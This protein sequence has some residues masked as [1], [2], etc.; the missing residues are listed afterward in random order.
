MK[1][2]VPHLS[3]DGWITNKKIKCNKI[4]EY[5]IT[6]EYSQSVTFNG[7]ISSLKYLLAE[8]NDID[9]FKGNLINTLT[10][11]YKRYFDIVDVIVEV[12]LDESVATYNINI[13]IIIND[14]GEE[15]VFSKVLYTVDGNIVNMDDLLTN[16]Y[17]E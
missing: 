10:T 16:L 5:F 12:S 4:F 6:S 1:N 13:D 8:Y 9:V 11:L 7:K 3:I 2:A 17:K 15:I 14:D